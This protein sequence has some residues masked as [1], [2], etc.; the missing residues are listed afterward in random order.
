MGRNLLA[1]LVNSIWSALVGLAV[2][3]IYLKYL[4]IEAYGLI[5][6]FATTQA[7]LALLDLGLAPT[8]N[9][10]I[11]RCSASGDMEEAGNL[12]HTLA[13][14]YGAMAGL[15][16]LMIFALAPMVASHWLQARNIESE[17]LQRALMLMGLVIACRWPIGLYQGALMG[18]QRLTIS[19]AVSMVTV[20]LGSL[21]AVAILAFI[22][23]TIEAFFIWQAV[24]ALINVV[25]MRM[26]AW[27]VIRRKNK[28]KFDSEILKKI[29]RFSA[30][31]SGV[32][33]AAIFLTQ[34]DKALLS[35]MLSLEDFGRYTLAGV[36]ASGLTVL[37][38][39]TFNA[40]YPRFSA[41]VS[42][43]GEVEL[44]ILYMHGTRLFCA[45]TLPVA[46]VMAVFSESLIYVWT[47]NA[48]LAQSVA[49]IVALLV[50]GSAL[51][52][53]MHFPY[54][55]QLAYGMV[56]LPFILA[57]SLAVVLVPLIVY[58]T[59]SYGAQGGAAAWLLL[60][61]IYL[62]WGAWLTHRYLLKGLGAQWLLQGVAIPMGI[63]LLLIVAGR[64]WIDTQA[65]W[66]HYA[67]L[68]AGAVVGV[69]AILINLALS[70]QL[71]RWIRSSFGEK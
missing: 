59:W 61:G 21:G 2:V 48:S 12:L 18:L 42:K 67:R 16:T 11:A 4:G 65:E 14:V 33:I 40:V 8:I 3:P 49:P 15:I 69:I 68:S 47:G 22:S 50:V 66:S 58:L 41:L 71:L 57:S 38:V 31:M 51:N 56:R 39:P 7:L 37:I 63:S 17:T 45:V 19:S 44:K 30:G 28:P 10:E 70:P 36:V 6:F 43:G 53:V 20:T 62:F 23:P 25:F 46:L 1:G 27:R 5:G 60:N 9:R 24:V 55:L 29:W 35:R 13:V 64:Q 32:A 54:A 52:G 34:L 26:A